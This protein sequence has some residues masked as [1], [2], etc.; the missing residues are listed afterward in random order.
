L[1]E[2][3]HQFGGQPIPGDLRLLF[4]SCIRDPQQLQP[5]WDR[6]TATMQAEMEKRKR[7]SNPSK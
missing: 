2:E 6:M 4:L 5:T 3:Y 1:P 7:K